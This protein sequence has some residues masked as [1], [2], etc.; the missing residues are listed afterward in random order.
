MSNVHGTR[1]ER[2]YRPWSLL[3]G[4]RLVWFSSQKT[5][6]PYARTTYRHAGTRIV[7]SHHLVVTISCPISCLCSYQ[8][9]PISV[10]SSHFSRHSFFPFPFSQLCTS[11]LMFEPTGMHLKYR[12]IAYYMTLVQDLWF[13]QL[14]VLS[15]FTTVLPQIPDKNANWST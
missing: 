8:L 1:N 13:S 2:A 3:F 6:A 11:V 15:T 10:Q 12:R 7:H 4:T 5:H 9:V 14:F